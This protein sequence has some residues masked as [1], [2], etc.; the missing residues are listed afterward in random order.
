MRTI[1][2]RPAG[3]F[4]AILLSLFS[5]KSFS[6]T[7]FFSRDKFE[8]GFSAGPLFFLGDLG[9][10]Q[11]IGKM[12]LKDANFS[13]TKTVK[14]A[15]GNFYAAPWLGMRVSFNAGKLGADDQSI[16]DKGGNERTRKDRNLKF[17][18]NI[19]EG[20]FALELYPT[21]PFERYDGAVGKFRPYLVGG[22]GLFNFNPKGEYIGPGGT[23]RWVELQPLRLEGQ[24]MKEYPDRKP[25]KLTQ[26]EIPLGAGF[27]YFV[28]ENFYVGIEFLNRKTFTDYIDDVSTDYIDN[29]LFAQYLSPQQAAMANQLYYR[30]NIGST[31]AYN[32]PNVGTQRGNP[33]Q[34]DSFFSTTLKFGWKFIDWNT[35]YGIRERQSFCPSFF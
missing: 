11:G 8:F 31:G 35:S 19:V 25:Y 10:N 3:Y 4:I 15:Y 5:F 21:V 9:G 18:S 2:P 20:F 30:E 13:G 17:Q 27:K 26:V 28:K 22:V 16:K 29:T 24:G 1:L 12:Y 7:N 23:S 6:Q 14:G 33:S 32:R 34:N